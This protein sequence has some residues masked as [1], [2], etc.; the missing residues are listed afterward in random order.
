MNIIVTGA[1]RGIGFDLVKAFAA[2]QDNKIIAIAR[3]K[4]R[5]EELREI[6][7]SFPEYFRGK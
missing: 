3:S 5:L 1:S 2:D 4:G 6:T 7:N